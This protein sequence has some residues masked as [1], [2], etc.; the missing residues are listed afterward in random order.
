MVYCSG[1][2]PGQE[3]VG[4]VERYHVAEDEVLF[5]DDVEPRAQR[6]SEG[7]EQS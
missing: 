2:R 7:T 3:P 4:A 5:E 1:G 6:S